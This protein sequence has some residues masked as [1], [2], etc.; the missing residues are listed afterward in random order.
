MIETNKNIQDVTNSQKDWDDFW[1]ESESEGKEF[2]GNRYVDTVLG[3]IKYPAA[4]KR[5]SSLSE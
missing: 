1:Y 3:L 5:D 4:F 2:T